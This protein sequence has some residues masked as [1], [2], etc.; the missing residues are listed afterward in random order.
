MFIK[1]V[2]V[3][4]LLQVGKDLRLIGEY[5]APVRIE[6]KRERVEVR[7]HVTRGAWVG[8]LAPRPSESVAAFK[9]DE[10]VACWANWMPIAIPPG[11]APMMPTTG[12]RFDCAMPASIMT[13]PA[14][15]GYWQP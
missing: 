6:G 3:R 9:N 14:R 1:T 2:V 10:I 12:L 5:L 8:V 4:H 15:L 7:W 11:P 13:R